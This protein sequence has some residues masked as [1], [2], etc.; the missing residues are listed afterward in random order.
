[1][2]LC[3][4]KKKETIENTDQGV[5]V[6]TDLN[7][8][9][10][11]YGLVSDQNNQPLKDIVVSDGY[12]TSK[13]DQNGVYQLVRH[14]KAKFVFYTTP[15]D[16]EIMVDENNYPIFYQE[17]VSK[18]KRIR[19]D[20]KLNKK[21]V[22]QNFTLFAVADPQ[23][24]NMA[25]LAR[26]KN[27]TIAD[28]QSNVSKYSNVIGLTLG[29]IIFDTPELWGEMKSAMASQPLP[30]F[31]TIG[32][33][34]HLQTATS[35][36]VSEEGFR[37]H[38]GP[39]YYSFDRANTHVVVVDNVI[40]L[41]KQD[42]RGGLTENHWKWLQEDLSHVSKDKMVVFACHIPFRNGSTNNHID[43]YKEILELLSTFKEAHILNG[44]THYQTN[45]IHN[46]KG[47]EIYEHVHGT[48][49]GAW[50]NSTI[51]AD[52]TPNGYAIY[53][54]EGN[55]M[56]NWKYKS[57]N[58]PD[59]FQMRVYNAEHIF[60]PANNYTYM[61]GA[62]VNLNL[63]GS[64][65]IVANVWNA[66]K[67]WKIELFQDGIK[68]QDMTQKTTRDFWATYYHLEELG[69]A[70]GSTFD[71]SE[72]HFYV[73]KLV[74]NAT[75]ANFEVRATDRFGNVYKSNSL[76]TDFSGIGTYN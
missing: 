18:E 35:E 36:D 76:K 30:F 10:T 16:G 39:T 6:K 22:E 74:G 11:L 61:F 2:A 33:H 56:K 72:S 70:K 54:I 58:H 41:D 26:F 42:Y 48:A 60:G 47:K 51:C 67:D 13:T 15:A 57:T 17:L 53:E 5:P 37:K 66:D 4:C 14:K 28:I 8:A 34:D 7:E 75:Q 63:G 59:D 27:E 1:M 46:I 68:V 3:S 62:S 71:R 20:F 73:G 43:Y 29:D 19:H 25:E 50:W 12:T 55:K 9:T 32:N 65:W 49:G 31:Q 24:R 45:Y 69:K 23:C 21:T 38:F 52:G 40:Y 64:G 44:H